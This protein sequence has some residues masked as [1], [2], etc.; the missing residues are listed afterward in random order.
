MESKVKLFGHP[1]HQMLVPIPFGLLVISVLFD[2]ACLSTGRTGLAT[3]SYVDIV[4]GIAGGLVA[5]AFGLMDF[6]H[7][8]AGTRAK[9]VGLLHAVANL[10]ALGMFAIAIALRYDTPGFVPGK[11][12]LVLEVV[13]I[14]IATVAGWLGG[15]LVDRLGVGVDDDAHLDAPSSLAKARVRARP[16]D[17]RSRR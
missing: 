11:L 14:V 2:V 10:L 4:A 1:I 16:R 3:V 8:P 15:E 12:S 5:A 9:R 13:A 17:P 6:L 7:I